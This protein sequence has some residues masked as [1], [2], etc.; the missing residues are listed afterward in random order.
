MEISAEK[1]QS[2]L[3]RPLLNQIVLNGEIALYILLLLL[4]VF[5]RFYDLGITGNEP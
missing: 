4:A 1:R 5:T 2:W 3:D